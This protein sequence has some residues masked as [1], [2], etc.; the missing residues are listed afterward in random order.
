MEKKN[1]KISIRNIFC[2]TLKSS[3]ITYIILL[4]VFTFPMLLIIIGKIEPQKLNIS[5][6]DAAPYDIRSPKD[7]VDELTTERLKKEA[8]DNVEPVYRVNPSVQM[9]MKSD[10]QDF[11]NIIRDVKSYENISVS[12]K[13]NLVKDQGNI[14]LSQR[15]YL[16]AVR[17]DNK[18][19]NSLE[20]NIYD[21]INQIMSL[22]VK[23]DALDYEKQN[24]IDVFKSLDMGTDEMNLGIAIVNNTMKPNKYLDAEE[25]QKAK[26]EE[27]E[28][29]EPIIVKEGQI[30]VRKGEKVSQNAYNVIK[31][32]DLLK[33]EGN[34][35]VSTIMGTL[36]LILLMEG[37]IGIYLYYFDKDVLNTSKGFILI[38]I[39]ILTVIIST[40]VN[41]ISHYIMPVATAAMLISI[42]IN[43]RLAL[44]VNLLLS[45]LIGL[46][47]GTDESIMFM[48]MIGGSV[49]AFS[50]MKPAQRYNIFLSGLII[51]VVNILAI[52][53]FSLIKKVEVIDII[54]RCGYGLL[55]GILCA[56]LT[57]GTLPIW[58]NVFK[59]LTPLKLLELLNLNQPLLKRLLME[60]PGTYHH[61]IVVGNLSEGAAEAIGANG[62]LAKVGAYYHDVGKLK[63]PYFF[64]ENQIGMDNPH[65]KLN[66]TLSTMIIT[67][68]TKDG[69]ALA[70]KYNIPKE[71]K[72]II[73]QHHGDTIVA[74]FY[75]KALK[76]GDPKNVKVQDFRYKGPKPQTKEA[77][78][79]MLADSCEAAVRSL[80]EPNKGKIEEMVR[81]IVKGKLDDGQL[82]ECDLT[83]KDLNTITNTFCNILLGIFHDRIEY[84][85]I[86]LKD[87]KGAE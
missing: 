6:G 62:L 50:A 31:E 58:E 33:E 3:K 53:S 38:L 71:I 61:S 79:V 57:I 7:V 49:G 25:T 82:R 20:N 41:N 65:D 86:K 10:I 4:M 75:Y 56:I 81:N 28:K 84:P 2:N 40:G 87:I 27:A 52:V 39:I 1:I 47:M 18:T 44:I 12:K 15:E 43:S 83:F 59:I 45:F 78:I 73:L 69:L 36:L 19:L 66:P 67:N 51:G 22:G 85:D 74:Y 63:R 34:F 64:K 9:K 55:N 21:I 72:D 5:I 14:E 35:Q 16:T 80:K 30:I 48:F 24:V 54:I 32:A 37:I 60:A 70:E 68:H 26:A 11:F 42:V 8:S 46:V 17:M 23:E 29:I 76:E 77:A 13:A